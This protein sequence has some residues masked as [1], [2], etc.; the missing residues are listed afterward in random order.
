MKALL[1][2]DIQNDYF[3]GKKN[4]L[5]N[6]LQASEQT[7]NILEKF[8]N[9]KLP[10][11]HIQHI[12]SRPEASFF[13]S[14]TPRV[15]IH[16]HVKPKE[17]DFQDTLKKLTVDELVICGMMTHM[18]V[19]ATTRAAKDLGY[20]CTLIGD[21]CANCDLKINGEKIQ[22][23][24]VQD[25]FLAVLSHYNANIHVAKPFLSSKYK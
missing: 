18:C 12:S 25:S 20:T 9:E 11:V 3:E 1:I 21:A 17:T 10:I 16:Y 4:P 7:K 22:A 5:K 19:N 24:E 23:N 8:R 2:I 6:L 14:H 13:I 15:K